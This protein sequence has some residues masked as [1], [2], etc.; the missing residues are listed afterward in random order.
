M[1]PK[2]MKVF[3]IAHMRQAMTRVSK[4]WVDDF[5]PQ[6]G[7]TK[8]ANVKAMPQKTDAS[9][10]CF[11]GNKHF[12]IQ[13]SLKLSILDPLSNGKSRVTCALKWILWVG[14]QSWPLIWLPT[15]SFPVPPFNPFPVWT[16]LQ[17]IAA[18]P[19]PAKN[20]RPLLKQRR[21][22]PT[23]WFWQSGVG[24]DEQ[25]YSHGIHG[26]KGRFNYIYI[27]DFYA[28]CR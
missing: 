12:N 26:T 21:K 20:S 13:E 22:R 14:N 25:L 18:T 11:S 7:S 10:T 9:K 16:T 2:K 3:F 1:Y 15:C 5:K 17:N 23:S 6:I 24:K 4:E 8:I 19:R 28:K 27:V